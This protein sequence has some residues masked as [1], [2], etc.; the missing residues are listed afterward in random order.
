MIK[1]IVTTTINKPTESIIKFADLSGWGLIVVGDKKTPHDLYHKYVNCRY[2]HPD[3]Q[4]KKYPELSEAIGWNCIQRRNIGFI[5]A[6]KSGAD[7]IASIDDDNIPY[8]NWGKEVHV[9]ETV[10][11]VTVS[12]KDKVVIDP[13]YFSSHPELWHRGFPLEQINDRGERGTDYFS[14]FLK[15]KIL[16]Q[17][18]LWDGDPDVDAVCRKIYNPK[19]IDLHFNGPLTTIQ[20]SPFNSQNTFIA[21]EVIPYYMCIPWIGRMDDIWG[22]YIAE[23]LLNT[24]PLYMPA[25]VRQDRNEHSLNKDFQNEVFGYLNTNDLLHDM[26]NWR[27]YLPSMALNAFDLYRKEY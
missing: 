5:E 25:T 6:Y 26:E 15:R 10:E 24:R 13:L 14:G 3:E 16:I 1:Y 4:E 19:N 11:V 18:D 27:N 21:R 20:Y 8:D 23:Y 9:G 2:I 7:I 17:E 22:G 12:S